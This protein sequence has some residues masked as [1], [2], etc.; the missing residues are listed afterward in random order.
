MGIRLKN[1][2]RFF[3]NCGYSWN[4]WIFKKYIL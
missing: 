3:K 4:F 1:T 2:R